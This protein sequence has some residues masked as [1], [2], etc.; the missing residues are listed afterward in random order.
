LICYCPSNAPY[1]GAFVFIMVF[2]P[3]AGRG[4]YL[5]PRHLANAVGDRLPMPLAIIFAVLVLPKRRH[6][7]KCEAAFYIMTGNGN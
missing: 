2:A 3:I 6:W 1:V 4:W 5:S 7:P